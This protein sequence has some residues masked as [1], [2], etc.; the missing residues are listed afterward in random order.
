MTH[1]C[2]PLKR[3]K[4]FSTPGLSVSQQGGATLFVARLSAEQ[5]LWKA[6]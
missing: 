6:G 1:L 3:E 2:L 4:N 5:V